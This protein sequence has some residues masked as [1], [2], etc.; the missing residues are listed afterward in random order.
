MRLT[1]S[2]GGTTDINVPYTPTLADGSV[3]YFGLIT[4]NPAE[5]FTH[6]DFLSTGGYGSETFGFDDMTIGSLEQVSIPERFSAWGSPVSVSRA[7][8]SA[9]KSF[10]DNSNKA[11]RM[12]AF[13]FPDCSE[14]T[15]SSRP[16]W[17]WR[18]HLS[19]PPPRCAT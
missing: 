17:N 15:K 1:L 4:N 12:R 14:I 18:S 16:P 3:L 2:G 13:L 10:A 11:R 6:I 19:H 5:Q 8:A 7:G 9:V